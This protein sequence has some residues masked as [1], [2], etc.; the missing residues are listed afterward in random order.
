MLVA[1]LG[2][3]GIGVA[4]ADPSEEPA[5]RVIDQLELELGFMNTEF[6]ERPFLGFLDRSAC[7]FD[8]FHVG[9]GSALAFLATVTGRGRCGGRAVP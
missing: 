4:A 6:V 2:L 5:A 3:G 7:D 1:L 9:A 8:P